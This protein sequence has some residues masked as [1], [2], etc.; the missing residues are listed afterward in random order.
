[1]MNP[2]TGPNM[3]FSFLPSSP[4]QPD[5]I[6][7]SLAL[8]TDGNGD[9]VSWSLKESYTGAI[10]LSGN[11]YNNNERSSVDTCLPA[12]CFTFFI[13]DTGNDGLC[14]SFGTGGFVVRMNGLKVA[15]GNEFGSSD[16]HNLPC[17]RPPTSAPTSAS[18]LVCVCEQSHFSFT[19]L[20][21]ILKLL[22]IAQ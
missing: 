19:S 13:N 4:C 1:M 3:T 18:S 11:G 6:H 16:E 9:E 14:C 15:T 8:A 10:V 7:F 5:E 17:I 2:A 21:L 22:Y 20:A 12:Q